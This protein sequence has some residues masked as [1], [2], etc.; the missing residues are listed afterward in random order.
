[1]QWY[2]KGNSSIMNSQLHIFSPPPS[3]PSIALILLISMFSLLL[4]FEIQFFRYFFLPRKEMKGS[5]HN[6]FQDAVS[7][8]FPG[9]Q[10][11]T[12][13]HFNHNTKYYIS[14][15]FHVCMTNHTIP[16]NFCHLLPLYHSY[17]LGDLREKIW[18]SCNVFSIKFAV[19][20]V[21][22]KLC[23]VCQTRIITKTKQLIRKIS[24]ILWR[25]P[26]FQLLFLATR[27]TKESS[28]DW[29]KSH[30]PLFKSQ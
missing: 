28:F 14:A 8:F 30:S 9:V 11:G 17:L 21:I 29:F 23:I 18:I 25:S 26:L 5:M 12:R 1:M 16:P 7:H 4:C 24:W 20:W 2:P 13:S 3:I 27:L 10:R 15:K 19:I 6:W 22:A